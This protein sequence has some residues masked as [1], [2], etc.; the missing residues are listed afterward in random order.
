MRIEV[1]RV[2]A[3]WEHPKD[4]FGNYIP[5]CGLSFR[6]RATDWMNGAIKWATRTHED[7][8]EDP[9]LSESH[10]F[11]W[12]YAGGPPE[13]ESCMPDF[14]E[15]CTHYQVYEN[16]SE[17]TPISPVFATAEVCVAWLVAQGDSE[18]AAQ[19]FVERSSFRKR[20]M[21]TTVFEGYT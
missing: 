13:P 1:R 16:G 7:I 8:I 10:P 3:N 6:E 5:L 19:A 17:G 15:E 14:T 9:S 2:K 12:Q 21:P 18:A 4:K 20:L 11:Y